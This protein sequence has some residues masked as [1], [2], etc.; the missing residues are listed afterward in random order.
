[1]SQ[2]TLSFLGPPQIELDGK[3]VRLE[4]RKATALLAY[5]SVT[6][7]AHSRD[8]LATLLWPEQNQ[9]RARANLRN[10]LLTLNHTLG[11]EWLQQERE[12]LAF[13][14]GDSCWVDVQ[15]F[16]QLAAC[17][18]ETS[19]CLRALEDATELYRADFLAGFSLRDSAEFD[20][21]QSLEAELLRAL[22]TTT[23]ERLVDG[24]ARAGNLESAIVHARRWV[25]CDPLD[26]AAQQH[27]IRLYGQTGQTAAALR[28]Y[29]TYV[30]LLRDELGA[31]P[32]DDL[33]VL[34][35]AVKAGN[36]P[37]SP[38]SVTQ[39][40][41]VMVNLP[42]QP[43]AFVGRESE[44]EQI[45]TL[46]ADSDCRLLTLVGPGGAGKTRLAVEVAG[47]L[48]QRYGDGIVFVPLSA[49]NAP[50]RIPHAIA[51]AFGPLLASQ[52]NPETALFNYLRDK[53]A[54]LVLDSFEHLVD[55][56]G[57][58]S[59]ILAETQ[60]VKLL[61][62][63]RERL[64]LQEEW[65]F[66]VGGMVYPAN[67]DDH[68]GAYSA[69][70][71]FEQTAHQL[72]PDFRP[73]APSMARICDLVDGLPLGIVLAASWTRL[74][75]CAEIEREIAGGIGFLETTLQNVPERHRSMR[76]VLDHSWMLLTETEQE[77]F[78]RL[79]IF[80]GG[81][82]RE[83]AEQVAGSSLYTLMSLADKSLIRRDSA[84][85][86][87]LHDL[88]R[89]YA[90]EKTGVTPPA[91]Q[92]AHATYYAGFIAERSDDSPQSLDDIEREYENILAGWAYA[93]QQAALPEIHQII[94]GLWHYYHERSW[95]L[96]QEEDRY[97]ATLDILGDE[98]PQTAAWIYESLGQI[99]TLRG[100]YDEALT[101]YQSALRGAQGA[102]PLW[103]SRLLRKQADVRQ[104]QHEIDA[105][106]RL[107]QSA[108]AA[109][110]T[111]PDGAAWWREWLM[112]Q[113]ERMWAFYWANRWQEMVMVGEKIADAVEEYA[114]PPQKIRYL[115]AMGAVI[116]R[117]NRYA[118]VQDA[119][120]YT[121]AAL[122]IA[123]E[124][125]S[126]A[127]IAWIKFTIGL[128]CVLDN[129][130]EESIPSMQA[131]LALTE[132]S[133]DIVLQ[134][135]CLNY[136]TMAYRKQ[137]RFDLVREYAARTRQVATA[138]HMQEYVGMAYANECWLAWYADD[139]AGVERLGQAAFEQW[140]DLTTSHASVVYC[141]MALF[142]LLGVALRHGQ[143][144]QAV[145]YAGAMIE[146]SQQR[147]PDA[148]T[149]ALDHA[150]SAWGADEPESATRHLQEALHLAQ[151]FDFL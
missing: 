79:T 69:L 126:M 66:E 7:Q 113:L 139:E 44:I 150:Q 84:G 20:D 71:L 135:R 64:H 6:G 13:A 111:E 95:Y 33:T 116:L 90:L 104:L 14:P 83:A 9:Q 137:R 38:A 133:G 93:L 15:H 130:L 89:Q 91:L 62:T 37:E 58:L 19:A 74:L 78:A 1:M 3:P 48:T 77:S 105:A 119:T 26:E 63:S 32:S 142:P 143:L 68:A 50:D 109:L 129:L 40:A 53:S 31:S 57:L 75:T 145:E 27:L 22:L 108:E 17:A 99:R 36:L 140:G 106:L 41:P 97:R 49:L 151:K 11:D 52:N 80:R 125:G 28:Q 8:T 100:D 45:G 81:F 102:N 144:Q 114:A 42:P 21:W 124:S 103:E 87:D 4:R 115:M 85:R 30:D 136:L 117:R 65:L 35:E 47:Q 60:R 24:L 73:D 147:L 70:Q 25:A 88:L 127:D 149:A 138:A 55:G 134:S 121:R 51:S 107:Y 29:H 101:L 148:L 131:A 92:Q 72:Q 10:A 18:D 2:L 46:L 59:H 5:L 76:A 118:G 34:Y 146:P 141:W 86:Y 67:G 128:G 132:R 39:D 120:R 16:Q 112:I 110:E 82:R 94:T 12:T 122:D 23:L 43:T 123:L 96:A 54:L 98:N 61:V 56:A